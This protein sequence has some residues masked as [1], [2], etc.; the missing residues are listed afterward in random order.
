[1]LSPDDILER[2]VEDYAKCWFTGDWSVAPGADKTTGHLRTDGKVFRVT[3][4]EL[5]REQIAHLDTLIIE[6]GS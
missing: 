4:E 2:I 3:V 5:E 6:A 1:M